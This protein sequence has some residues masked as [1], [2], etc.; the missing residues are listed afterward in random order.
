MKKQVDRRTILH[1]SG[2]LAGGATA[3][4]AGLYSG[5]HKSYAKTDPAADVANFDEIAPGVFVHHGHVAAAMTPDNKGDLANCGFVIGQNAIA[6]ID[7]GGT[8]K[9]GDQIKAAIRRH[10]D[11][12]IKYVI[13]THMHPDHVFG[14]AAFEA[15]NTAFVAH[16]KMARGLAARAERYLSINQQTLGADAFAGT[17]VV[18]PILEVQDT[19][20][21]DLGGRSLELTAHATAHT[22]NDLTIRDTK[23]STV[24]MGDLIFSDHTPTLD[25]SVLGWLDLLQKLKAE[26]AARIVP[27]HGPAQMPWP[28]AALP[29][30]RYFSKITE[31]IRAILARD[32]RLKEA[33]ATVG[34]SEKGA[35]QLFE[36]YHARNVSAAFA[37]LEWE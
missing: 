28:D 19:L 27:G 6:V 36:E 32:G 15:E 4:A 13:N 34:Q 10:S 7:T 23:T 24:F 16:H 3:Y 22:D 20:S 31:E 35:W 12:P 26:P 18:L 2:V 33:I 30:E 14:N 37:E 9:F 21:L 17:K 25:G 5:S 8:A 11:L 29:M 1:L